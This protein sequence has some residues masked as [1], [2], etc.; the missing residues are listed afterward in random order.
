M[1]RW[2]N[3]MKKEPVGAITGT[4]RALEGMA[5]VLAVFLLVLSVV[6]YRESPGQVP[7][8]FNM[9]GEINGWG[10]RNTIFVL[11]GLGII[12]MAVCNAAAYN[13]KMVNLPIR[14]KPQ[15]LARQVTLIGRMCRILSIWCGWLFIDLL[16]LTAS[17]LWNTRP[18]CSVLLGLI[19]TGLLVTA[20]VYTFLIYR[21]GRKYG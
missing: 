3:L 8:H 10:D 12:T 14:L 20:L 1:I 9:A 18:L 11:A 4:D 15:C 16:L 21:V 6:V 17:P 2:R 5:L 19:M 7:V 13:Y